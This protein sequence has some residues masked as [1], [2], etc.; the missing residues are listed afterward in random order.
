MAT[1]IHGDA[2]ASKFKEAYGIKEDEK[3]FCCTESVNANIHE[4]WIKA[5][6]G[7]LEYHCPEKESTFDPSSSGDLPDLSEH[8][9]F[10]VDY[11]KSDAGKKAWDDM[12]TKKTAL[13]VTLAKC[14]KTGIDN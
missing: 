5:G 4:D 8:N 11:L 2:D 10:L 12:K 3:G 7:Y 9:S 6:C 14:M 13:G 1:N